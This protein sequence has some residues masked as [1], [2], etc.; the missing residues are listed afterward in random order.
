MPIN[1]ITSSIISTLGNKESLVPIMI[2]D[3][4]DSGSLTYHSYKAG[5]AIEGKDRAIDEFGT[6]AIW[7]GGIPF[8]KKMIDTTIY[9]K[10]NIHPG[11]DIRVVEN[12]EYAKWA[13]DNAKGKMPDDG[14]LKKLKFLQPKEQTVKSAM[15]KALEDGGNKV[16][17][18]YKTKVVAATALTLGSFFALTMMKQ[19]NTKDNVIYEINSEKQ[20]KKVSFSSIKTENNP[21]FTDIADF[22]KKSNNKPSFKGL[23]DVTNS[24]LFNPVS[25]MQVIDAGI[26]T[27]RLGCSRNTTEFM[28]HAIKEG[29]FLFFLY[30]FGKIVENKINQYSSDKLGIPIDTEIDV[31]TDE[32]LKK[33][34]DNKNISSDVDKLPK[35]GTLTEKLNF[36][37]KNPDNILVQ[38]AKKSKIVSE[39]VDN[40][41]KSVV[42][43]SKFID[44]ENIDNLA[45][46]L[47][48]IE[49]KFT[50]SG[51]S[52]EK[53]V[54]NMKY[55]KIASV[56]A[57]IVTSCAFLGYLI[58][59]AVYK[60]REF[61]TGTTGFHVTN[62][63]KKKQNAA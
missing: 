4:V 57:N 12:P 52:S 58:P 62:D 3:G 59:K 11:V 29:G 9:K 33:A 42:D 17:Y 53:F 37:I 40:K 49:D 50:K 25:N 19:K 31:I 16:D 18:L 28:E 5:G 41:G 14:F 22:S 63:I 60:Y 39:T 7:I 8:Y 48:T 30:K 26:T 27:A 13:K 21:L 35:N 54:K 61:K 36:I 10:E 2:K 47:K 15:N 38:A 23:N 43:T 34:L 24:I 46:N 55:M 32:N 20:S 44:M 45:Q 6:Q 56:G 51:I 1:N